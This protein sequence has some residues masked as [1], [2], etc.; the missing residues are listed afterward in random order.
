MKSELKLF[1]TNSVREDWI[2]NILGFNVEDYDKMLKYICENYHEY[3]DC[4]LE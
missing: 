4:I 3:R 1:N 2:N